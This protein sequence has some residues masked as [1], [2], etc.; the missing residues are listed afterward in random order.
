MT[1]PFYITYT[2]YKLMYDFCKLAC[3]LLKKERKKKN[4]NML[5][6]LKPV[7]FNFNGIFFFFK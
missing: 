1:L 7:S 3:I 2:N 5:E 4:S 6:S